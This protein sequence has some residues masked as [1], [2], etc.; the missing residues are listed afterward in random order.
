MTVLAAGAP[1]TDPFVRLLVCLVIVLALGRVVGAACRKLGQP[2][3]IGEI[4]AGIALGP[5]LLGLLPGDLDTL[6]FPETVRPYL[7]LVAQ[8]GLVLFMFIVGLEVDLDV[9]RRSG[10]RALA[11]SLTSIAFPFLLGIGILGTYLH[12]D[13]SCVAVSVTRAAELGEGDE[14]ACTSEEVERKIAAAE[15]AGTTPPVG[16]TVDQFPFG[17][18][19]G[20]SMC[21]TAFAVLARILAERDMFKIP[22]GM[23]LIACAAIDDIV[24]FTLLAF[25]AALAGGGTVGS[26]VVMLGQLALF[27]ALLVVV[28]RP[29]LERFVVRSYR[30]AGRLAP[31]HLA[32]LLIG[33]LASAWTTSLIGVH[34]LI[35]A[36]LFGAIV[37]RR[38]AHGLFHAVADRLDGVSVQLL[39][40]VFFVVA[41]QG[42]DIG[43][44]GRD[45]IVPTLAILAV[46][47]V[48]KFVGGALAARAT[49]VPK[50]QSL[51]VGTMMNTR[52]LAEL[53]ILQVGRD[54]G[55]ID[56]GAYTMLVIMAIVTTAMSGPLLKF[57]YP[58][59]W[60]QRDIAEAARTGGGDGAVVVVDDP[61]D[62]LPL[63]DTAIGFSGARRDAL[64][65]LVRL[66]GPDVGVAGIADALAESEVLRRRVTDAGGNATVISRI[67]VDR[68]ADVLAEIT[69]LAPDVVVCS[70]AD[71]DLVESITASGTD[72]VVVGGPVPTAG[73]IGAP[74]G[75]GN[76]DR[77]ALEVAAR[78]AL[79]HGLP[80]HVEGGGGRLLRGLR[81]LGV[82]AVDTAGTDTEGH[83]VVV[84]GDGGATAAL[85]VHP[86]ARD[87][88]AITER[89]GRWRP[90]DTVI[91]LS[92]R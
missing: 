88:V 39:L 11:I 71:A 66:V 30:V 14:R 34:E 68:A 58:D 83:L 87:R 38:D 78:L 64:V 8:L 2:V 12:E 74:G 76:A 72:A 27:V 59:R 56:D 60:L 7:K 80:L 51:A 54:A 4:L 45:D 49:G 44:L 52:G 23:L 16:R 90:G 40:P 85:R 82:R 26:V 18:F 28:V 21:G 35:G 47:C 92:S 86:G 62:A 37:P 61:A 69:R 41:G 81:S 53:V 65:H 75:G 19:I 9:V 24:A 5:S 33:L 63:V 77:A 25:A 29:L 6:L 1:G 84:A 31:E 10:K 79:H 42:V 46:A 57:V 43:G 89:L 3:V 17:F 55:V 15:E 91:P 36:F 50:R 73:T 22:L 70:T 48:G 67:T 20:V 13:H 32:V